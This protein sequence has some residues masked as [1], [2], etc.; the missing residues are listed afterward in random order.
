MKKDVLKMAKNERLNEEAARDPNLPL[1]ARPDDILFLNRLTD[2]QKQL[3]KK[4][5]NHPF[6]ETKGNHDG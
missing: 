5:D 6:A 4:R 3:P 1:T 2:E